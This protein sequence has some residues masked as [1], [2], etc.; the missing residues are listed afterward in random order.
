M[1]K[2]AGTHRRARKL[3]VRV[4]DLPPETLAPIF[5]E[6]GAA[7]PVQVLGVALIMASLTLFAVA[8]R[9]YKLRSRGAMAVADRDRVTAGARSAYTHDR[10]LKVL[11]GGGANEHGLVLKRATLPSMFA[12]QSQPHPRIPAWDWRSGGGNADG[13]P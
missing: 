5:G 13:H 12:A 8:V 3:D 9:A 11:L 2:A 7:L 1:L 6:H 10:V 4:N